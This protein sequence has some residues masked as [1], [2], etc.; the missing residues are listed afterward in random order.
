MV[1]RLS[2]I[3]LCLSRRGLSHNDVTFENILV[4]GDRGVNLIDYDQATRSGCI[5]SLYRSFCARRRKGGIVHGSVLSLT[6]DYIKQRIP[7]GSLECFKRFMRRPDADRALPAIAETEEHPARR[8]FEAWRMAQRSDASSPGV[9]LAYYSFDHLGYHFPGERP[10][11]ARWAAL[12]SITDYRGRRILEL[13]CNMALLSSYLLKEGEAAACLA[14][15]V[16]RQIIES[17]QLVASAL[18][19][20]PDFRIQD[21]DAPQM[22]EDDL[23][24]FKP[25]IVFALNV[26]EWVRDR[27]RLMRFLGRFR[28][29]I[30]E[31]HDSVETE[32]R[33]FRDVGFDDIRLV[34]ITE[35][36]RPLMHCRK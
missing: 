15:D 33:R 28:E 34:T 18:G 7:A 17:A 4:N 1:M 9:Q 11:A 36:K 27:E 21:L 19:V 31:G 22:W 2:R 16:D 29:V 6:K 12:R 30:F 25:D 20:R 24:G 32:I 10:W 13:G 8:L 35:R 5:V 23:D 14:V 3:L 26:L